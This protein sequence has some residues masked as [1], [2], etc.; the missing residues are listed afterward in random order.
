M[1]L[2]KSHCQVKYISTLGREPPKKELFNGF[3]NPASMTLLRALRDL[4]ISLVNITSTVPLVSVSGAFQALDFM[5]VQRAGC[6][7]PMAW[8]LVKRPPTI[9]LISTYVVNP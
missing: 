2:T 1:P 7:S 9:Y 8:C 5:E 4:L 3:S 6:V